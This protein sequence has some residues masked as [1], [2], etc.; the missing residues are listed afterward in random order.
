MDPGLESV[1]RG[2]EIAAWLARHAQTPRNTESDER[3]AH[4]ALIDTLA[5]AAA[6]RGHADA[7][8][9]S[10]LG[11]AGRFA[12]LAHLQ[13]YDDLH[14]PTTTHVSAVCV[15]ATVATGGG[16][17]A[18]LAGAKVMAELGA[19]LGWGHYRDGWHI[20][21]TAG[22]PAA[23]MSAAVALGLPSAKA[24]LALALAVP[25]AGGVD[26]AFGTSAKSL[27]VGFAVDAGVRAAQ[28][29]AA[30]ATAD[31]SALGQWLR[32]VGGHSELPAGAPALAE[33]IAV[34]AYPCCYALQRPI[35]AVLDAMSGEMI[36]ATEVESIRVLAPEVSLRP[37]IHLRPVTGLQGKFSL[38]YGIAAAML[39]G[40]PRFESFSDGAV[41]RIDAQRIMERVT[42]ETTSGGDNLL[43]GQL[44]VDIALKSGRHRTAVVE[45][46]PGGPGRPL[47]DAQTRHKLI[48]CAGPDG[49]ERLLQTG[50]QDA[51]ALLD[52]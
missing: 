17:G 4:R 35:A 26:R 49:A 33:S 24:A 31:P 9:F 25:G 3:V 16:A 2:H 18:Y 45:T 7:R 12:A 15:A 38:A 37:L 23:A 39:D 10:H 22:A 6:G 46:P 41:R 21:C 30:G 28:L 36:A 40:P 51:A 34:K 50:W 14:I 29:A 32:L 52:G 8:L 11:R 43:E 13:D 5:V 20:T 44:R 1:D 19:L 42:V 48:D 27:Q 47:D